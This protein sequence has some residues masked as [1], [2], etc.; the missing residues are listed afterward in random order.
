MNP[1]TPQLRLRLRPEPP[2][3]IPAAW[4]RAAARLPGKALTVGVA[5]WAQAETERSPH[6]IVQPAR[7]RTYG[8][9]PD[10]AY[11]GLTRLAAAR[12]IAVERGRGR[13]ASVTLLDGRCGAV[14]NVNHLS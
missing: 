11:D 8:V 5:L 14:A 13:P 9:A 10:A 7:L 4:V 6:F 1:I 3:S 12:L 2:V